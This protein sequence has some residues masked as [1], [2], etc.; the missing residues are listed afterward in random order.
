MRSPASSAVSGTITDMTTVGALPDRIFTDERRLHPVHAL[1]AV[2]RAQQLV[3][4]EAPPTLLFEIIHA[5]P[6]RLPLLPLSNAQSIWQFSAT[7]FPPLL[8]ATMW[9][10][11]IS[12]KLKCFLQTA[13][14]PPCRS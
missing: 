2:R 3:S 5:R 7:V 10:P 13:Q 4:I 9:S 11:A 12:S 8:Q 6:Q 1:A 14:M